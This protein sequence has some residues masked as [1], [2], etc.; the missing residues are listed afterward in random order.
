MKNTSLLCLASV[1]AV[2]LTFTPA[3]AAS[4]EVSGE[5]PGEVDALLARHLTATGGEVAWAKIGSRRASGWIE[6]NRAKIPF[7][8]CQQAPH[9]LRTETRFPRPGTLVQGFDGTT[10]WVLHPAQGGRKL[11]GR[12]LAAVSASAWLRPLQHL[13]E[14]HAVRRLGEPR[15]IEGRPMLALQLGEREGGPFETWL[16]DA[17]TVL[18]ARIEKTLDAGP[19][20]LVSV[21]Q[22]FEDYRTV[23]GLTLP[24]RIRTRLPTMETIL[25][26][27]TVEHNVTFPDGNF[28]PPF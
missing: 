8:Q 18:L 10:G 14:T 19:Q 28:A 1:L 6:R 20:G 24:F 11:G 27:E 13:G 12:E 7:V 9:L 17:D 21:V 2:L 16:F 3:I 22:V 5:A 25:Q 26:F 4:T 23:D 15:I